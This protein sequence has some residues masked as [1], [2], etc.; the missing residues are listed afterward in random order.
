MVGSKR[1]LVDGIKFMVI[2]DASTVKAGLQSGVLDTAKISPDLIPEFKANSKTQ[3]IVS[4]N[5][6]KNLFTS[7]LYA[8]CS[9]D[10]RERSP[11]LLES[12]IG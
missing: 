10:R 4:P 9:S 8:L 3:V 5:N 12:E 1:P 6:G 2:P 11:V 7:R